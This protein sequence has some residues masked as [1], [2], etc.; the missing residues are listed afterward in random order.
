[1]NNILRQSDILNRLNIRTLR[2]LLLSTRNSAT[3][4]LILDAIWKKQ[5]YNRV[6][7]APM[8]RKRPNNNR[9]RNGVR[10]RLSF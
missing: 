3:R 7:H 2:S 5:Q 6:H 1:M 10:Q 4:A 8:K 9:N